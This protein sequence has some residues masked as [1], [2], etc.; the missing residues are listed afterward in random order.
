MRGTKIPQG[1][2]LAGREGAIVRKENYQNLIFEY[3]LPMECS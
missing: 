3:S 1:E 2:G